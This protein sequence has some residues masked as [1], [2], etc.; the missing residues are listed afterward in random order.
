MNIKVEILKTGIQI[1]VFIEQSIVSGERYFVDKW[2]NRYKP[3]E[4]IMAEDTFIN[5]WCIDKGYSLSNVF[6]T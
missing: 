3:D 5:G 6:K 4:L 1:E 2:G